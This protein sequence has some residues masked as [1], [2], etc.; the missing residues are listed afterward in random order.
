MGI[1]SLDNY[2]FA[3]AMETLRPKCTT[4]A[5]ISASNLAT[6]QVTKELVKAEKVLRQAILDSDYTV[7]EIDGWGPSK[8]RS[9]LWFQFLVLTILCDTNPDLGVCMYM[10]GEKAMG[11][12]LHDAQKHAECMWELWLEAISKIQFSDLR[13]PKQIISDGEPVMQRALVIFAERIGIAEKFA[14]S[15]GRCLTDLAHLC[16][17]DLAKNVQWVNSTITNCAVIVA[18]FRHSTKAHTALE[19][20]LREQVSTSNDTMNA[21]NLTN[22]IETRW[23]RVGE[24]LSRVCNLQAVLRIVP[25]KFPNLELNIAVITLL[26]DNR[27]GVGGDSFWNKAEMLNTL[28]RVLAPIISD[29]Q[30]RGISVA[31]HFALNWIQLHSGPNRALG[32][33]RYLYLN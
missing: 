3:Q 15:R 9:S 18:A 5:G 12:S 30:T 33:S 23:T 21:K 26:E 2:W 1:N 7:I 8:K 14:I 6:S 24:M 32:G 4:V 29:M 27:R 19:E 11:S 17:R 22:F 16:T 13:L 31:G 20:C 25:I 28:M 10:T